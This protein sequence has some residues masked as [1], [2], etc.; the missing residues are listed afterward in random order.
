MLAKRRWQSHEPGVEL[1]TDTGASP[2]RRL[3][4]VANHFK[5]AAEVTTFAHHVAALPLP[6]G[7]VLSL[8]ISDNSDSWPESELPACARV[9]KPC[10]NLGYLGGCTYAFER[11]CED[12]GGVPEWVGVVNTDL[13]LDK[14]CLVNLLATARPLDTVVVAPAVRLPDGTR[15]NPYLRARPSAAR[16]LLMRAVFRLAWLSWAWTLVHELAKRVR[17]KSRQGGNPPRAAIYAP[18]G[19]IMFLARRFFVDGGQLTFGS[20]MFGEELHIAE[21]VR[22]LGLAVMYEPDCRV[23]HNA[24]AV[25]GRL[26][27]ATNRAWRAQSSDYIWSTYFKTSAAG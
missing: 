13:V 9:V 24:H 27:S 12:H 23:L 17:P 8:V 6:E 3:L 19:S 11:W 25:V 2:R 15:Q 21:Q 4:L 26:P 18:H 10:K 5:N 1:L 7:W 20:F 14:D 22:R 16:M